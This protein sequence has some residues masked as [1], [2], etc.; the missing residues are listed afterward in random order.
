MDLTPEVFDSRTPA[1][2]SS[3]DVL[4]SVPELVGAEVHRPVA[5]VLSCMLG[6]DEVLDM[7]G[8]VQI[9]ILF[10]PFL[11]AVLNDLS[12]ELLIVILHPHVVQ[13]EAHGRESFAQAR[14]S[15]LRVS[16]ARG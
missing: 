14:V 1:D 12:G 2:G 6:C 8:V 3:L 9:L 7:L 11:I 10:P 13:L 15:V 5:K 4:V 16:A